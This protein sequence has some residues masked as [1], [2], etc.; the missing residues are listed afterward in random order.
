MQQRQQQQCL[1]TFKL[2]WR[3]LDLWTI[4]IAHIW[5]D[6][7][8]PS[9]HTHN[10]KLTI[11]PEIDYWLNTLS[12]STTYLVPKSW[13]WFLWQLFIDAEEMKITGSTSL[14]L[15]YNIIVSV[16]NFPKF[17]LFWA[18]FFV[19]IMI[20]H[21]VV[22]GMVGGGWRVGLIIGVQNGIQRQLKARGALLDLSCA[23]STPNWK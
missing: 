22:I 5:P 2:S 13:V 21:V 6:L 12:Y 16:N 18:T 14:F 8:K 1:T 9:F 11:S 15:S 23:H 10:I 17:K 19:A 7:K 3:W 20:L 4:P